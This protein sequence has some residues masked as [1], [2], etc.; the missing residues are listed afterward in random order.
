[1]WRLNGTDDGKDESWAKG[2]TGWFE[3]NIPCGPKLPIC[4]LLP[5]IGSP[6]VPTIGGA[7]GGALGGVCM[8]CLRFIIITKL[9]KHQIK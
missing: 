2:W 6:F 1:M 4:V 7:L 5:T 8:K 3:F 9:I